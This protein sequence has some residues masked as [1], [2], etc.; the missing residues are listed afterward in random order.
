MSKPRW[1]QRLVS[2]A[3]VMLVLSALV[4]LDVSAQSIP[5]KVADQPYAALRVQLLKSGWIPVP[6]KEDCGIVCEGLRGSGWSETRDCGGTGT[7]P[8]MF[9]FKDRRGGFLTVYTEGQP[10]QARRFARDAP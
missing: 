1:F 3:S 4:V 5:S 10:P 2:D 9:V 7:A 6:Q 8:C